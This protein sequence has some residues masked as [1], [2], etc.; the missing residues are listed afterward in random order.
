MILY[1]C[2]IAQDTY[3]MLFVLE[4]DPLKGTFG[5][6]EWNPVVKGLLMDIKVRKWSCCSIPVWFIRSVTASINSPMKLP[7]VLA[8]YS[9]ILLGGKP[10]TWTQKGDCWKEM[11]LKAMSWGHSRIANKWFRT[12]QGRPCSICVTWVSFWKEKIKDCLLLP[13]LRN[14]LWRTILLIKWF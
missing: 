2:N 10:E 4:G 8:F 14:F 5:S 3:S 13:W 9:V 7:I 12:D 11:S 1:T 6:F